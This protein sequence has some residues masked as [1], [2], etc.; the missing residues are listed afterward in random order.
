VGK[1]GWN[2]WRLALAGCE[3]GEWRNRG[4][5]VAK[6]LIEELLRTAFRIATALIGAVR[7]RVLDDLR[8]AARLARHDN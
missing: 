8:A 6:A 2:G 3:P 1:G 7:D 4:C 5:G